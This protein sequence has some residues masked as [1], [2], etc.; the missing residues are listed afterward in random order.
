VVTA[1]ETIP[2]VG[3]TLAGQVGQAVGA[4]ATI[5]LGAVPAGDGYIS[6]ATVASAATTALR[7]LPVLAPVVDT[8]LPSVQSALTTGCGI[9]VHVANAAAA[10][11][12]DRA[13]APADA[14]GQPPAAPGAGPTTPPSANPGNSSQG[15]APAPE[16]RAGQEQPAYTGLNGGTSAVGGLPPGDFQFYQL[17]NRGMWDFGRV[18]LYDYAG[19][20][21]FATPGEFAPG[22]DVRYPDQ[23]PGSAPE[24]GALT[25][26]GK[27][28]G[29][30]VGGV[31]GAATP[32]S[33][34]ATAAARLVATPVLLAVLA[35]TAVTAGL[36]RSWALR[37]SRSGGGRHRVTA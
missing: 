31:P 26:K 35:V 22:P 6:G 23:V 1:V 30:G 37:R 9:T 25:P 34:M 13:G 15:N 27:G 28:A 33:R 24:T 32:Q 17:G 7:T 10:P 3:A 11:V 4:M 12:Q 8:V 36:V 19:L 18:P 14:R 2:L 5:P 29:A 21:P 16:Q 20:L